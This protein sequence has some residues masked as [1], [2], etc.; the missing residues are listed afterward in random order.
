MSVQNSPICSACGLP[1]DRPEISPRYPG[2]TK[3][4]SAKGMC[5]PC[6]NQHRKAHYRSNPETLQK[7]RDQQNRSH[8][9]HKAARNAAT[10][11]SRRRLKVRVLT[12]LGGKCACCGELTPEFLTLDHINGGGRKHREE[13][14]HTHK[15]YRAV[16]KEG[17]P[18]DKYRVLCWNCNASIGL[19]GSCPHSRSSET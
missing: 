13:V 3:K 14:G 9:K 15:L 19:W 1:V 7:M 6:Y 10:A 12:A 5:R 8:Q 17:C 11:E 4:G 16:E 2:D 18:K